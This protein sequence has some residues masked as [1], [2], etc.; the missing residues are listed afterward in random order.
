LMPILKI[1]TIVLPSRVGI[2]FVETTL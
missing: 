2:A 1:L